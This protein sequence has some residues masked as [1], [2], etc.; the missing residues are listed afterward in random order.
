MRID[1]CLSAA[2]TA[3]P[4]S[5]GTR[6]RPHPLLWPA[7]QAFQ[8]K[9]LLA[10]CLVLTTALAQAAPAG[11]VTNLSGPLFAADAQGG[12]RVLSVGSAVEPGETLVTEEKTYAQVRFVDQGV[13]TLKPGT[14]FKVES[15]SFDAEAPDKDGAVFSLLKGALR[16]VTGLIGK[17]GNQDAYRM[18][19]PT[20]TIGIRGTGFGAT[21]CPGAGCGNLPPGTYVDVFDG[22]VAV[23]PPPP[24]PGAPPT[25]IPPPI[26][27]SA[28]QFGFAPPGGAPQQL[29]GDSGA[30]QGFTPPPSFQSSQQQAQ[31]AP[32]GAPPPPPPAGSPQPSGNQQ[33]G[34]V[35]R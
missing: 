24:P 13:V 29:P 9:F 4:T 21:L 18:A 7:Q 2:N 14:Q 23:A 5:D 3:A 8:L 32:A 10:G 34:C 17:R 11:H 20:A 15:F 26:T 35:V 31:Q 30:G 22:M 25:F 1:R 33:E 19:T 28:G 27:L 6:L 16:K 12:R